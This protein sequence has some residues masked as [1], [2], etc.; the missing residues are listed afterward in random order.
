MHVALPL[1]AKAISA[2]ANQG[3]LL[4]AAA[5]QASVV[6]G[7]RLADRNVVSGLGVLRRH[8]PVQR[9]GRRH[10]AVVVTRREDVL[11]VLA[12][13]DTFAA[14]YGPRLPGPF[15]LG[16]DGAEYERHLGQLQG[17]LRREDDKLLRDLAQ[18]TAREQVQQAR[19]A[20]ALDI[21]ADLIHPV[22]DRAL[23]D[24]LGLECDPAD[25]WRWAQ[26]MFQDIFL[27]FTDLS[28]LREAGESAAAQLGY[29][30]DTLIAARKRG[31]PLRDDVLARLLEQ[32]HIA[33][34]SAL[35]DREIR[36][37][38]IGLAIGWM[39]HGARA[40]LIAVDGLLDRP[41]ALAQAQ[42]AAS[43]GDLP[44]LQR[45]LWEA[46]RFRPVQLGVLRTCQRDTVL[47]SGTPHAT[48]VPV[49][50]TVV[51]GTHSAMW[52]DTAIPSPHEFDA[53]RADEQYLLF[54][55]DKHHCLGE[56][57]MRVQLPAMLAPLL[58]IDGL[59]RAAGSA[60]TLRW[61][62]PRPD[63]L[64]VEFPPLRESPGR[65]TE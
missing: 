23:A 12:D 39:W 65:N 31:G 43:A 10:P 34:D 27:N 16:L 22:F 60:G 44:A 6:V 37:S 32:Q 20:G 61:N 9:V 64:R 40:A 58:A 62:G 25:Q 24:Y 18:T 45:V 38:I 1:A 54:G 2:T 51:V 30:V 36:H 35:S 15:V 26:D 50:A 59:C 7:Q 5:H 28:T 3:R 47:G 19:A 49:G 48:Q 21:G 52:D 42:R 57:A 56:G 17:A 46:L 14:A 53:T 13:S 41:D 33:P 11:A 29:C 63:G 55:R 8:R 4:R